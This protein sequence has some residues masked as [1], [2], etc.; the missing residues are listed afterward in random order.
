MVKNKT[1]ITLDEIVDQMTTTVEDKLSKNSNEIIE[2]LKNENK[3][4]D[5]KETSRRRGI[6]RRVRVRP[7][8]QFEA[9]ESQN[10]GQH[11][12]NSVLNENT[13]KNLNNKHIF[14]DKPNKNINFD[15]TN[16][17]TADDKDTEIQ[18]SSE[19]T[20]VPSVNNSDSGEAS[21]ATVVENSTEYLL[22]TTNT[23]DKEDEIITTIS[24]NLNDANEESES[25][26]VVVE[27]EIE[28]KELNNE[29]GM[30]LTTQPPIMEY[31]YSESETTTENSEDIK[32]ASEDSSSMFDEVK[33]KLVDLFFSNDSDDEFD[34]HE[35]GP[36]AKQEYTSIERS[37]LLNIDDNIQTTTELPE[38]ASITETSV[39]SKDPMGS[40]IL[41]T[42]TS[43]EISHE[44]EICYRGRCVKTDMKKKID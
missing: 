20:T 9:A 2:Q 15:T 35:V 29:A 28:M 43:K 18:I 26:T 44:T 27:S 40:L 37:K 25:T 31:D 1:E 5:N 42:S 3:L 10:I 12:F 24:P 32:S 41:A 6:W 17:K 16:E 39:S 23:P 7:I 30:T 38:A 14:N 8:D 21:P 4:E 11:F 22:T 34:Y 19:I 13:N 36:M 33:Q